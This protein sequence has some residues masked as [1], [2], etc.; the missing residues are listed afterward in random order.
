MAGQKNDEGL[1][2]RYAL[3]ALNPFVLTGADY[4]AL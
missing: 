3:I 2:A 4:S 1:A